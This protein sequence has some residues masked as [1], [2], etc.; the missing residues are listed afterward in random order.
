MSKRDVLANFSYDAVGYGQGNPPRQSLRM[1]RLT[2]LPS[3]RLAG[4]FPL[5]AFVDP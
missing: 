1:A 5:A 2:V 3:G 4:P